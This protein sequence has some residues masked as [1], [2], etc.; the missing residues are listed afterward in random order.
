LTS[1]INSR[2][3]PAESEGGISTPKTRA[4]SPKHGKIDPDNTP[5]SGGNTWA[6][7]TGGSDTAGLGGRGGPYRLDAGHSVKQISDEMKAEV[8]EE[9]QRRARQMAKEAL[10]KALKELNLGEEEWERYN[11]LRERVAVQIQQ[12]RVH[13]KDIKRRKEERIWLRRQTNGELDDS[14]LVDAVAGEKDVFK[15]RGVS[16]E[17]NM[18]SLVSEP[19]SIKLVVDVSASMYRFNGYDGRLQRLLEACVMIMEALGDDERFLLQIVG[20]NGTNAVIPFV[21]EASSLDAANQLRVLEAMVTHTQYTNAGDRTL[22]AIE[23]AVDEA[24]NGDLILVITDAN[25]KRYRIEA[26]EVSQLI[27][28]KNGSSTNIHTHLILIGS[29]GEEANELAQKIPNGRAQICLESSDLPIIIKSIV[30]NA[31]K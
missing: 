3:G 4:S 15:R 1:K 13:L 31:A 29:I 23:S 9:A 7:G 27:S 12:L 26:E 20:H 11:D 21:D 25:L 16:I 14:R 10:N 2:H 24:K 19:M 18:T 22:E 8:S 17:S 30:T 5:H 28:G 6:G